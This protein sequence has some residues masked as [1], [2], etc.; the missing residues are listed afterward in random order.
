[1]RRLGGIGGSHGDQVDLVSRFEG[2]GTA[3]KLGVVSLAQRDSLG[4]GHL[5]ANPLPSR[6]VDVRCLHSAFAAAPALD[7]ARAPAEPLQVLRKAPLGVSLTTVA[8]ARAGVDA[9]HATT[10]YA[11]ISDCAP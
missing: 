5:E 10:R 7:S 1:V 4:V 6:V 8:A 3:V 9:D 11:T 2:S